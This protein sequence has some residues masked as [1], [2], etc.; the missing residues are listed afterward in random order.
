MKTTQIS[1]DGFA[2]VS[3]L[4]C[5]AGKGE[6][7]WCGRNGRRFQYGIERDGIRVGVAWDGRYFCSKGCRDSYY[8]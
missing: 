8:E 3:M 2:R 5:S 7:E 4:R 1:H 6:C